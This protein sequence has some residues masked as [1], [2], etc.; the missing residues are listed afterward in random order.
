M[1]GEK[2]KSK[3]KWQ[4]PVSM[5]IFLVIGICGGFFIGE[6]VGGLM[7][8]G[9]QKGEVIWVMVFFFLSFLAAVYLQVVIHEAGHLVFG[10][11]TGYKFSS[12]RIG[13]FLVLKEGEKL[14]GKCLTITGTGGQCLM[15]PP[16]LED[17]RM[18]YVLYNIGGVLFNLFAGILFLIL[19][20]VCKDIK[21]LAVIFLCMALVG[22]GYALMNGI[23]MRVGPVDNDGRNALSLGKNPKAMRGLW[24]Q[25]KVSEQI[26]R[27]VR[28]KDMPKEWF[29]MPAKEDMQNSMVAAVAVFA[30]NRL[31]DEQKFEEA[32]FE[33]RRL[34]AMESAIVG[35]HSSLLKCDLV[36]CELIG[37]NRAREIEGLM[38]KE[39]KAFMKA[40]HEFPGVLRTEYA[41][42]LLKERDMDAAGKKKEAFDKMAKTY[43]YPSD[44]EG[45]R[46]LMAVAEV[47]NSL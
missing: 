11:L 39:Q 12:F 43:P 10:L 38:D 8:K 27:G 23:P 2:K 35:V 9:G 32:A 28:L 34:L 31:M 29:E 7:K 20:F 1:R 30:C 21:A 19:H 4:Q 41:L 18:P 26:A 5:S 14:K 44:I 22:W 16:P 13:S 6:Y 17:G 33:M 25:L 42:A 40:M 45:E 47:K 24:I 46:E 37:E 3:I 36:F 15:A